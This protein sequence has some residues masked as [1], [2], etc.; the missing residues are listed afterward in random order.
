MGNL[1][2]ERWVETGTWFFFLGAES[3]WAQE[4][5]PLSAQDAMS[6]DVFGCL[7]KVRFTPPEYKD[8]KNDKFTELKQGK[9]SVT[10]YHWKFTDLSRYCPAIAENPKEMFHFE[11]GLDNDDDEKDNND[12][13]KN[14]NKGQSSFG[15]QKTQNFKRSNNNSKSSSGGSNSNT[16]RRGGN[17]TGSSCF[18]SQKNSNN[19]GAQLCH[20]CNNC[21][22]GE[23]KRGIMDVTHAL[24]PVATRAGRQTKPTKVEAIKDVAIRISWEYRGCPVLIEDVVMLANLVPLE[25]V[26]FD[27]ILGMDWLDYNYA[28]LN[29]C[30]KIITFH[31]PSMP[32]VTFVGE[33]SGLK[34]G[35]IS[36]LRAKRMLRKGCQGYLA[37]VVMTE[38]TSA[39]VEGVRVVRH[40]P[41]VFPDYLPTTES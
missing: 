30:Q 21:H 4:S 27:V 31:Q 23:Y 13:Q 34:H 18:Q 16:T 24:L 12:T 11:N 14:N 3:W 25:I 28:I 7:F 5:R 10:E 32:I 2:A 26:D 29:C 15:P 33:R 36:A 35:V 8:R 1:P 41:D 37:H 17:F 19:S 9:M 40:F 6:W 38:D 20:K 22:Y 39:H